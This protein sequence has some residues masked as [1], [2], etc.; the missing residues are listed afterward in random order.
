MTE[1]QAVVIDTVIV[2]EEIVFSLDELSQA[3]G[4]E[5]AYLLLLVEEGVLQPVGGGSPEEWHFKGPALQR[6]RSALRLGR[7]LELGP[8]GTALVLDLLEQIETLRARLRRAGL[9]RA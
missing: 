8:A 7:D 3:C 5:R 2:E 6:A 1:I 9:E 4:A